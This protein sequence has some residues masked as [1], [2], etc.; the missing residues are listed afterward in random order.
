MTTMT[1]TGGVVTGG[2]DTHLDVNVAAVCDQLGA[3]LATASF[4]T[5][6]RGHRQ[7]LAWLQSHGCIDRVGVEGTGSYGAGL[8]RHLMRNGVTVVEV[9]R[10]NRQS[11]RRHGKTDTVD[12]VSAARAAL[13]GVAT[14]TPKTGDGAVESIRALRIVIRSAHKARSQAV[15]QLRMLLVTAPAPLRDRLRDLPTRDLVATCA[16]LRPGDSGDVTAITKTALRELARRVVDLEQQIDRVKPQQQRLVAT[17]APQLLARPGIGTDTAAA[18]L[19]T[20][21]D[22][23]HRMHNE[24]AFARLC[25]VAPIAASSGK[26]VRYRL[27]R[28]GDRQA[29]AAL[30]RIVLVRMATD[31]AT[32]TYVQRRTKDGL[33]KPEIMRCLKR[34]VAREV[35]QLLP[36]TSTV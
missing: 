33:S 18:L 19:V 28:G 15:N 25:G 30:W 21:G 7:L 22:N 29:N 13:A 35:F 24:R 31:P 6:V 2:V 3:V 14:G 11:R 32:K 36:H 34:Y 26:T 17:A 16:A 27:N 20:A 1:D 12:A 23:A 5:T 10:P 8:A 4:D 9:D